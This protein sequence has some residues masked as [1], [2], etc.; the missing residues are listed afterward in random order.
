MDHPPAR[1]ARRQDLGT[2][3]PVRRP[4]APIHQRQRLSDQQQLRL[5]LFRRIPSPIP[6]L[7]GLRLVDRADASAVHDSNQANRTYT[8]VFGILCKRDKSTLRFT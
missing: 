6:L 5:A 7:F 3:A 4:P 2:L 8:F 1:R